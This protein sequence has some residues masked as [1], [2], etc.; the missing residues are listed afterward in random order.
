M[1]Q[2]LIIDSKT[3]SHNQNEVSPSPA[4]IILISLALLFPIGGWLADSYLGR[5]K[6]VRYST[7]IM[8]ISII[9][10]IVWC[11]LDEYVIGESNLPNHNNTR[12]AIDIVLCIVLGIAFVDF[13]RTMFSWV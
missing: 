1:I 7:W 8:W 13:K 2:F 10:M 6:V 12:M 9:T 4:G 11:I 5:Y 3:L